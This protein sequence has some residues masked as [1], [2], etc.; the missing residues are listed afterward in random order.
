MS[1]NYV[2][3][4]TKP[5]TAAS[6]K[7]VEFNIKSNL[8]VIP[9]WLEQC[10]PHDRRL[11]V[12]SA[13][14]S[15][16]KYFNKEPGDVVVAVKHALPRLREMGVKPDYCILLD[17]READ[18]TSTHGFNRMQ[19]LWEA[20]SDI[21]FLVASM[22]HHAYA[23]YLLENHYNVVGWHAL[24][25]EIEK[26]KEHPTT[27][28]R[29]PGGTSSALRALGVG[30]ALGFRKAE[31]VG[32]DSSYE[33]EPTEKKDTDAEVCI[34]KGDDDEGSKFF[35]SMEMA[36]QA[37]DIEKIISDDTTDMEV[38]VKADGMVGAICNRLE[39]K[40]KRIS[41]DEFKT[42]IGR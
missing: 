16:E 19:L 18:G 26:F 14:P 1:N 27:N 11:V 12:A 4:R 22:S 36:A 34:R 15:L 29:I 8:E 17:G 42:K 32:V 7:D 37:Q 9:T 28:L 38:V 39:N 23:K 20:P 33:Q 3:L 24:V 31:L 41:Y 2:P 6:S 10:R 30:Y 40:T 25:K 35:T 5:R 21:T 13:G